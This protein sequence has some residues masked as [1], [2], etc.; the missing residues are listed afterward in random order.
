MV[1]QN[2]FFLIR[3]Y[4]NPPEK[5]VVCDEIECPV[6][7]FVFPVSEGEC[8]ECG[9]KLDFDIDSEG[10]GRPPKPKK[11]FEKLIKLK[12]V[13]K[14]LHD[15]IHEFAGLPCLVRI[16]DTGRKTEKGTPIR[17]WCY[18]RTAHSYSKATLIL[19]MK[20]THTR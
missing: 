13:Q 1:R 11:E 20:N 4:I 16:E 2:V 9:F 19:R 8:P 14:E 7:G 18:E 10:G 15:T 5:E 12:S 6:C 3:S 17:K